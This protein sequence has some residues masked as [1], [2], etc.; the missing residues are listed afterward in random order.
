[1]NNQ[2][3]T[4]QYIWLR[5]ATQYSKEGRSHTVEMGIPVPLGADAET[6][7]KLL[8]EA[9][10][11]MSQL[12]QHVEQR[13]SQAL[14]GAQS[15]H[16]TST[17]ETGSQTAQS[18]PAVKAPSPP[19]SSAAP[20]MQSVPDQD[21]PVQ[22]H[23]ANRSASIPAPQT[24]TQ[25]PNVTRAPS[26]EASPEAQAVDVPPTRHSVG[27]SMPSSLSPTSAGG[28]LT[29][30][31]FV[32]YVG[33]NM[34]LS[35]KQA[36]DLL[37]V[38]TLS[39]INLREA[40][41]TL[42]RILAQNAQGGMSVPQQGQ[43]VAIV[44]EARPAV[45]TSVSHNPPP[46]PPPSQPSQ[47]MP[48]QRQEVAMDELPTRPAHEALDVPKQ[49]HESNVI[50]MR[51]PR[52]AQPAAGFDEEVD[53]DE[54]LED[55]EESDNLNRSTE[56]SP[57]QLDRARDKINSLRE[58]QGA[59]V[60]NAARLQALRNAADDEVTDEQ[61]L[62]LVNGVWHI[63]ALKKLKVDQVEALISWAKQDYFLDE[64]EAVLVVLEEERYAR[65][66]R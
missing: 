44:R 54:E 51:I 23:P 65:G 35:P 24:T 7:E 31:E 59:T 50:E 38:K 62:E 53:G 47:P 32:G 39:G 8:R 40:L 42:K 2:D 18:S 43:S 15:A 1:M 52:S 33:E 46:A 13:V 63:Q 21:A 61:I 30:P 48:V 60:T 55:L 9:E 34:H 49:E 14:G 6:R 5:Y 37:R 66:N 29:I 12:V 27:A 26:R 4:G 20:S 16:T 57:E 45:S 11:G 22:A 36:M 19:T 41:E 56:L 25:V 64:V 17:Q 10:T 58:M 3:G 28:S